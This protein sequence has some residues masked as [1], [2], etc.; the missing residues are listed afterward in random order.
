MPT[1]ADTFRHCPKCGAATPAPGQNPFRC[2]ACG[3][4]YYFNPTVAAAGFLS[5]G[6]GRVLVIRRAKDPA[7]GKLAIPGGFVDAGESAEEG[8]RR[9]VREEVGVEIDGLT[10]L[11]SFVNHYPYQG[12][13][14]PVLDLAF[15]ARAVDPA[16]ARPLDAVA[17]IEWRELAGIPADEWAFPSLRAGAALLARA[18]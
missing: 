3:F 16:S 7:K 11:G 5:D 14:Y 2:P 10:Y 9:E 18:R 4:V 17:G 12:V 6:Q 1:P 15:T 8:L 13:T